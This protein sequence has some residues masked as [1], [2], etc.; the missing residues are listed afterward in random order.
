[1]Q[2]LEVAEQDLQVESQSTHLAL[3][4][5]LVVLQVR[6]LYELVEQVKQVLSQ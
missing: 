3:D 2:N 1:M 5:Y 4:K 6:Q